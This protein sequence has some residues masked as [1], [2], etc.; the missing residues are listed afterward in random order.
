MYIIAE[1]KYGNLVAEYPRGKNLWLQDGKIRSETP[2]EFRILSL[3][4]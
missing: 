2:L 3:G 1:S 4:K